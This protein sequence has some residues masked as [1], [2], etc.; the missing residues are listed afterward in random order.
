MKKTTS[1]LK[2][3]IPIA[4]WKFFFKIFDNL[5]TSFITAKT[6]KNSYSIMTITFALIF[7]FGVL[8]AQI[9]S[10]IAPVDPPAEG[11]NIDGTLKVNSTIGDWLSGTGAGGF[12]L[13]ADGTPANPGTTFWMKDNYDDGTNQDNVF[14]GAY[15]INENPTNWLWQLGAISPGKND[16]NNAFV[17]FTTSSNGNVWV[18]FAADR[19]TGG[20]NNSYMDFEFL[21]NSLI[22]NDNGTF[23]TQGTSSGRTV[24]D[25][26]LSVA[27]SANP[28]FYLL[29]WD[30]ANFVEKTVVPG[31]VYAAANTGAT[32]IPVPYGAF[33]SS[34]YTTNQFIEVAVNLTELLAVVDPCNDMKIKTIFVKTKASTGN[35]NI[36]DFISPLQVPNISIGNANAGVDD[37]VCFGQS[38][39]LDGSA[40][41]SSGYIVSHLWSVKSGDATISD[42]NALNTNVTITSGSSATFV[43]TVT[44]TKGS[45]SCIATDEVT[46]TVNPL[47]TATIGYA[48]SPFCKVGT[49]SVSHTGQLGGTYSSTAGLSLNSSTGEIDL[50]SSTAG[51]YTVTYSFTDV[52]N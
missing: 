6:I 52:N 21:Q 16:M 31:N 14:S 47:P 46:I 34:T 36:N 24:G 39:Q 27:F 1:N 8:Q 37:Y 43:L 35:S 48:G 20:T 44:A 33:G 5:S 7:N 13:N 2:S 12:V 29:S 10:G 45:S 42:P 25:F 15:K 49:A 4:I 30:G 9:G 38:Y 28:S 23:T 32:P 26:I 22:K 19:L 17:H 11:F 51:T 40:T 18:I 3:N 50:A 41:A